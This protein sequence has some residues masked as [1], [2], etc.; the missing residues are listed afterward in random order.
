MPIFAGRGRALSSAASVAVA[1][2]T[3]AATTTQ[4]AE[5]PLPSHEIIAEEATDQRRAVSVRLQQRLVEAD[6]V[7]LATAIIQRQKSKASRSFVNYFLPG[8]QLSQGAWASVVF[9]PEPK[10]RAL[11][12]KREDEQALLAEHRADS[13]PLLGSWLTSPP[14]AVGRLTIYSDAGR[15]FAEWRLKN[16]QKTSEELKDASTAAG[17][18]FDLADGSSYTL[19]RSGDL[20]IRSGTTLI[21]VG[22]RIRIEQAPVE[23][24]RVAAP[25]LPGTP[26]APALLAPEPGKATVDATTSITTK[27]TPPVALAAPNSA[28]ASSSEA[29]PAAN[30]GVAKLPETVRAPGPVAATRAEPD[31]ASP[32]APRRAKPRRTTDTATVTQPSRQ[33][34][35][36]TLTTGDQI[37]AKIAGT[38]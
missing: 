18:R 38:L 34:R 24:V 17:R 5:L 6:A 37:S 16:G 32:L 27:L 11:G 33:K 13:R 4:A 8:M 1:I 12:L 2:L 22:E 28:T 36:R 29:T 7:R 30:A 14:A 21:A 25:R 31:A 19:T 26:S 35:A 20:E 10:F 15:I 3:V 9:N 23:P